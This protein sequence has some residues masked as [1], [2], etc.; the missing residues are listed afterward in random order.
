MTNNST[1]P[2]AKWNAQAVALNDFKHDCD[3]IRKTLNIIIPE[4]FNNFSLV[5][6]VRKLCDFIAEGNDLAGIDRRCDHRM[7]IYRL[8]AVAILNYNFK[9]NLITGNK[10][11]DKVWRKVICDNNY[12]SDKAQMAGRTR[13]NC[14]YSL[15]EAGYYWSQERNDEVSIGGVRVFSSKK[16]LK[17]LRLDSISEQIGAEKELG[18]AM[19]WDVSKHQEK[20]FTSEAEDKRIKQAAK[21]KLKTVSRA[22]ARAAAKEEKATNKLKPANQAQHE[23]KLNRQIELREQGFSFAQIKQYLAQEFDGV[24]LKAPPQA[25]PADDIPY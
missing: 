11:I 18:R 3:V 13:D 15:K 8:L 21:N 7:N 24:T 17:R 25:A 14:I 2:Q 20:Q 1:E 22:A 4:R 19:A 6:L 23:A 16:S 12:L 9:R 10:L 5:K